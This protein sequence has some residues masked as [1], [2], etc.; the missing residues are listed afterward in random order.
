MSSADE[1]YWDVV[2]PPGSAGGWA[3]AER[4]HRYLMPAL[5]PASWVYQVVSNAVMGSRSAAAHPARSGGALVVSVGNLLVGGG[6]KTPLAMKLIESIAADG[7]A[8]V[9]ISRGFG[10]EAE[11][12]DVVTVVLPEPCAGAARFP[13]SRRG[14]RFLRRDDGRLAS[15]VGDEGAMAA[16]HV[17]EV[18]LLFCRDK[19]AALEVAAALYAPTHVILDDAFQSWGVPR[20]VDIVVVDGSRPFGSGWLLPAGRLREPPEALERADVLGITVDDP[21][22]LPSAREAIAAGAG[23]DRPSFGICRR[24]R[25][26]VA[27]GTAVVALSGIARPEPFER[28]VASAGAVV[29]ASIRF[30]DHHDYTGGDVAWILEQVRERGADTIV[31]TEKDWVKLARFDPP[32]GRF[33][34]ARLSLEFVGGH[35]LDHIKKAAE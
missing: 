2:Y 32:P 19:S 1:P 22:Q 14:V 5:V 16:L 35:P 20:H 15:L 13:A 27:D 24:L 23:V 9:Y 3:G 28:Q 10:G 18:P 4:Y 11:R 8:P 26:D 30:P 21:H 7:G 34:V 29:A 31:T 6:G 25:F 33:G 12:L 17:P